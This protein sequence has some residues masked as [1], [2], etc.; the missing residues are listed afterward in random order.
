MKSQE[1]KNKIKFDEI[2]MRNSIITMIFKYDKYFF[3]I[4]TNIP[5]PPVDLGQVAECITYS[6][7]LITPFVH[8]ELTP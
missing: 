4:I 7:K 8:S 1:S 3:N 6:S 2:N 5:C